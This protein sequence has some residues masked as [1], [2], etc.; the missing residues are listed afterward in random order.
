MALEMDKDAKPCQYL[1]TGIST[2]HFLKKEHGGP[3]VF[4][5][6]KYAFDG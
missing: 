6:P 1:P 5:M 3:H 2:S 4:L